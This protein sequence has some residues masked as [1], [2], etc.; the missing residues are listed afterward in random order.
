[1]LRPVLSR[2]LFLALVAPLITAS[3]PGTKDSATDLRTEASLILDHSKALAR[4]WPG[5]WPEE[6]GFILYD[7][8]HGA[9]LVGAEGHPRDITYRSGKLP[10]ADSTFV[11]DYPA[12]TPNMMMM[13]VGDDW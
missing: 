7:P 1:M 13:T 12:G 6:Q 2:L 8:G 9:V 11:Y 4:I 3:H 5:Y 10:E